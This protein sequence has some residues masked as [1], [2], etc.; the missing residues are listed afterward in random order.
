[1][2]ETNSKTTNKNKH[3]LRVFV[4]NGEEQT[5]SLEEGVEQCNLPAHVNIRKMKPWRCSDVK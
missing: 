3:K 1:M 2:F 5:A 4:G